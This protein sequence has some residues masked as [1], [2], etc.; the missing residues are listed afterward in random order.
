[1]TNEFAKQLFGT[2][3]VFGLAMGAMGCVDN[4]TT[5]FVRQVQAPDPANECVVTNDPSALARSRG[6]VDGALA[7][8]YF[9]WLLVG[10]QLVRRGDNDTLRTESARVQ[11]YTAD[12]EVF[13]YTGATL[14]S[15]SQ[16]ISGFIDPSNGSEPGYGLTSL[17]LV[18]QGVVSGHSGIVVSRVKLFGE[19]LGGDEVETGFW[20]FPIEVCADCFACIEPESCDDPCTASCEFGQDAS[21]DCRSVGRGACCP[22]GACVTYCFG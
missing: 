20:D 22:N 3:L 19:T 12:V 8:S 6:Y 13:D 2:T 9:A 15:F 18:D 21:P 10:N 17:V 4:N 16:P 11:L 1:M 14:S 7:D 5:I